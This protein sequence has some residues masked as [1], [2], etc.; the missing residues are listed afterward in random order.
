[1]LNGMC[2]KHAAYAVDVDVNEEI[3]LLFPDYVILSY[4]VSNG[5]CQHKSWAHSE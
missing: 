1:M 3:V 2:G 5:G 4:N